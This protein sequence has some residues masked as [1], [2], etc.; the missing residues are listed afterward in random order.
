ML[1]YTHV[2]DYSE[3]LGLFYSLRD[4]HLK[5]LALNPETLLTTVWAIMPP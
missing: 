2:Q 3:R 1:F 5:S 4:V